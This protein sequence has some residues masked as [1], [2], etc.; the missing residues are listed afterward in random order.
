SDN[1][2][3]L[4]GDPSALTLAHRQQQGLISA[5]P[6][7]PGPN[8][9]ALSMQATFWIETVESKIVVPAGCT[10]GTTLTLEPQPP[11]FGL[12]KNKPSFSVTP[13]IDITQD[14]TITVTS[15]QI[16]YSQVVFLVFGRIGS[17][18]WPHVSV[19]TLVPLD[20]IVVDPS[21]FN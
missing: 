20:P 8:A 13:P 15:T 16:Q 3:F 18:V 10:A 5:P 1:I 14:R 4:L 2:A 17:L 12:P 6:P 21:V 9:Q 19:N 7:G 11:V